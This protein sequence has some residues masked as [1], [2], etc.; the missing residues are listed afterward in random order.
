MEHLR[1]DVA[2]LPQL[3]VGDT[4]DG[5]GVLYDLG[6]GHEEAGHIRPVLVH[7][8][9]QRCRRQRTGDVAA[10]PGKRMDAAVGHGPVE[11]GDHHPPPR[12]GAAQVL[13][14]GL[15]IHRAVQPELQ[16]QGAVQKVVAQIVRHQLRREILAPGHQLVG[17]DALVHL[18][19]QG[20]ELRLDGC[21]QSQR[22]PDT[23]IAG[24]DHLINGVAADAVLQMR[25][26]KIQQVGDLVVVFIPLTG[27]AD[28]HHAAAVVRPHDI[29][30]LGELFFV[31]HGRAAEFQYFQHIFA[32]LSSF[33][34]AAL[35]SRRQKN[36][37]CT[38]Y[39]NTCFFVGD[40]VS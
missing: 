7:I 31:R 1:P 26:A 12:R 38:P 32:S 3:R 13:V 20:V 34:A 33:F 4:L 17:A 22:I 23:H 24:A 15:L 2:Q 9:V 5:L 35:L 21:C 14:A 6:V 25:V 16:P 40:S 19:P 27:G 30:H 18:S 8:G 28:H 29:P 39:K 11:A 10:A 37:T 36:L